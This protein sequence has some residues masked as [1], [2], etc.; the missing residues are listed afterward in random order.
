MERM[1]SR[2]WMDRFSY[3]GGGIH[4]FKSGRKIRVAGRGKFEG[5]DAETIF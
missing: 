5:E 4:P 1:G 3:I 2:A